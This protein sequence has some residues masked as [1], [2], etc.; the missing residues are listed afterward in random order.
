MVNTIII[1]VILV[2]LS[3]GLTYFITIKV[4]FAKDEKTAMTHARN[5]MFF[6]LVIFAIGLS[7]YLLIK[8]YFSTSPFTKESLFS[9]L[10]ASFSLFY[11]VIACII[12]YLATITHETFNQLFDYL[13]HK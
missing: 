6:V 5:F 3:A 12:W 7:I 13:K 9:I 8:E 10:L 4:K 11:A 1:P 2:L